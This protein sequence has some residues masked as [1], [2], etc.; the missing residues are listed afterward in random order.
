MTGRTVI[1]TGANSGIGRA[2]AD[3]LAS[4]GAR[5]V[6]AVRS[7]EKGRQAAA[8][9][10]GQTEIR[11]LETKHETHFMELQGKYESEKTAIETQ[12]R[13]EKSELEATRDVATSTQSFYYA[14]YVQDDIR[15]SKSLTLDIG[16]RYDLEIP[17]SERYN[18]LSWFDPS[19]RSPL[20]DKVAGYPNLLGGLRF[21]G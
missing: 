18:R 7:L 9:M 1:V 17:R 4:A 11:E 5:V 15:V 13:A 14:A 16:L 21:V 20:A 3:A 10:S 19:L 8:K 2:A 6:L 12:L